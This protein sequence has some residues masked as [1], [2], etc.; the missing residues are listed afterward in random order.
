MM[1][2]DR[3]HFD[4]WLWD[5]T[6]EYEGILVRLAGRDFTARV[7]ELRRCEGGTLP[8]RRVPMNYLEAQQ[9]FVD[10]PFMAH[11]KGTAEGSLFQAEIGSVQRSSDGT[12]DYVLSGRLSTL[13]AAE[14][15]M[16]RRL[17]TTNLDNLRRRRAV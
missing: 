14:L 11:F 7:R 3:N 8:G 5:G 13:D 10:R 2:G 9:Q 1:D 6:A 12:F 15:E 16:L 4:V 17:A